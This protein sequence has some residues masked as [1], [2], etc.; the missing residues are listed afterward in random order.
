MISVG[1]LAFLKDPVTDSGSEDCCPFVAD[2]YLV[3]CLGLLAFLMGPMSDSGKHN[4][5][6]PTAGSV[7]CPEEM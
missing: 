3:L 6:P 2:F 1:S 5:C 7:Y 4:C